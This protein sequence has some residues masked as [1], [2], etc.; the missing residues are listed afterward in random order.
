MLCIKLYNAEEKMEKIGTIKK[1]DCIDNKQLTT[2]FKCGIR[3]GM[4]RSLRTNSLVLISDRTRGIYT[5][6]WDK[7]I[8]HYTGMG[9][10]G[11][12]DI[13]HMQNKTLAESKTNGIDIY[14]FEVKKRGEYCF[15]GQVELFSAPYQARQ[16]DE[17]KRSR[18][19]WVFPLK[20]TID[21]II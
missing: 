20:I 17:N 14:L 8:L 5:D 12:Q 18:L 21:S 4:R 6:V 9:L 11:D 16:S 7:G 19:V 10:V 1:G 15:L 2:V 3:G 13:D